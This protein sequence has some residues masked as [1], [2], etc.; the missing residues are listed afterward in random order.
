METLKKIWKIIKAT[1]IVLILMA[2]VVF[3]YMYNASYSEG[4]RAGVVYKLSKRGILFKT[5][6]GEMNTG[7]YVTTESPTQDNTLSTKIWGFSVDDNQVE[8]IDKIEKAILSG[9][10]VKL[11]YKEK[12]FVFPWQG[13]NK[14][15]IYKVEIER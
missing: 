9:K 13:D 2:I 3:V 12:Y 15:F 10:R 7:N 6:E 11:F 5:Y 4:F 14:A 1:F 8:V